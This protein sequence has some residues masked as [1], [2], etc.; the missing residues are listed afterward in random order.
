M[1]KLLAFIS[2]YSRRSLIQALVAGIVCGACNTSLLAL[3][4]RTVKEGTGANTL[5][6]YIGVW[7]LLPLSRFSS[8]MLLT[9]LGQGA[10]YE[11]RARL[12]RK[13]LGAPM[14]QLEEVGAPRLLTMLTEDLPVI[15]AALLQ[16]PMLCVNGV[17]V[18]GG[19][20][21][22]G[23]MSPTLFVM[24]LGLMVLGVLGYQLPV[25]R[26]MRHFRKSREASDALMTGFR[27]L[28]QGT[29]EL[30]LSRRRR[31]A[32]F[33]RS[34][35][36][37]ARDYKE[38][39]I[40]AMFVHVGAASWGQAM[41]FAI[42]GMV[43]FLLPRWTAVDAQMHIGYALVLLYLMTPMQMVM[44]TMPALNRAGVALEK[45]E[46]M[47]VSLAE[48]LPAQGTESPDA[49]GPGWS[50]LQ[51]AGVTHVY[52]REGEDN[53]FTMGP[54]DLTLERGQIIFLAGGNGS[55]KTTLAKLLV[56]LYAPERGE[57]LI[58]GKRVLATEREAYRHLFT[59]IFSDFFLFESL[60]GLDSPNLDE[61]ARNYLQLL[62]LQHKVQVANGVLSTTDLSQGQRKRLALLAAYLEDRPIFLFDEW[63][64]DQDPVFKDIFYRQLLPE[65]KAK[66]KMVI[67]ISHD[68]QYYGIADRIIKLNS[69][70]V[71]YDRPGAQVSSS[72]TDVQ[73]SNVG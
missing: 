19:L 64:A 46:A 34:L 60:L 53:N 54:I 72:L 70:Q 58:D 35:D 69:G 31:E 24:V 32:F 66:G 40:R 59:A 57:I 73:S 47:G 50:Q 36:A 22:M 7:L 45:V 67:V 12:S 27:A 20:L 1:K 13:I 51:L 55:G 28:T 10:L 5:W 49:I 68:D 48:E 3:I 25:L 37:S 30:K 26:A 16:I 4:N 42:I 56:G 61:E 43:L 18:V 62:Q 63:A 23:W 2:G 65:L 52:R 17:I 33:S 14:R 38:N 41:L 71:A 15:T 8:E 39:H 29:K 6:M 11:L 9:T 21:Y 44:N